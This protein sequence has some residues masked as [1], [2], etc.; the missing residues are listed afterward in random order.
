MSYH[1]VIIYRFQQVLDMDPTNVRAHFSMALIYLD[2]QNLEKSEEMFV[3]AL[4]IDPRHRSALY[5]LG[6]LYNHQKR[7]AEAIVYLKQLISLYP[8]HFN[9]AQLMGDCYMKTNQPELAEQIYSHVLSHRPNHVP[10]LHNLG[11]YFPPK[12]VHVSH[13][14]LSHR[15]TEGRRWSIG[16]SHHSV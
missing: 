2:R 16:I 6:V 4:T 11:T 10:A 3:G 1:S 15:C 5:N 9:G 7:E 14:L 12:C 8:K 13:K